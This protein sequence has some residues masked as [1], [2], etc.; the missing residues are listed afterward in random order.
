MKYSK[1]IC[2]L[3]NRLCYLKRYNLR[4]CICRFLYPWIQPTLDGKHGRV[5][6]GLLS[7]CF[8]SRVIDSL[9]YET[10]DSVSGTTEY[11]MSLC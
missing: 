9:D 5:G 3:S 2:H 6:I 7:V 8:N 10:L 4:I 1:H 11:T